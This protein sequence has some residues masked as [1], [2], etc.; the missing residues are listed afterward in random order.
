VEKKLNGFNVS[1]ESVDK[2]FPKKDIS[3]GITGYE[4]P[5]EIISGKMRMEQE[6]HI[7]KVIQ[8]YGV[9][10]DKDELIKALQYDRDQY[11]KGYINGY[12]AKVSDVAMEIFE[13]I[14]K[15]LL[16]YHRDKSNKY[17]SMRIKS[18]KERQIASAHYQGLSGAVTFAL[19]TIDDLKK[20]YNVTDTNVGGKDTE[21]EL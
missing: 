15:T 12:N 6:N 21:G 4:S 20:K 14:K 1:R 3:I 11:E 17:M 18:T 8:D 10:V 2:L 9:N 5:I 13:E 19:R 16:E 7:F